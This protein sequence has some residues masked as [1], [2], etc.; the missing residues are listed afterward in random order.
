M[1]DLAEVARRSQQP[2]QHWI[3][4]WR[5][6]EQPTRA[7]ADETVG[8]F[9]ARDGPRRS[10]RRSMRFTATPTTGTS[11]SPSTASTQ[12]RRRSSPSTTASTSK[13]PTARSLASS[14]VRGGNARRVVSTPWAP[15]GRVERLR[16]REQ[17][18]RQPSDRARNL[19][20][21]T[22]QRSAERIAIED[23]A[24]IIRQARSWRELHTAL[25]AQGMRYEK[26]GSGALLWIGEQPVKAST[27]GRDCSMAALRE[28]A[29]RLRDG[30]SATSPRVHSR[31]SRRRLGAYTARL[32][33][34]TTR[35]LPRT[36][37]QT[38]ASNP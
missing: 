7:Q 8:M 35:A 5:E 18:E 4:S 9:L 10:T 24:T 2:V 22:G 25:A 37:V 23:A 31:A 1:I 11:T 15:D 34:R 30:V 6:G 38:R 36:R 33:R 3:L 17:S 29:G 26:K 14:R 12:R 27:A 16:P 13:S 20:E 28:P 19:E 32:P 21:R